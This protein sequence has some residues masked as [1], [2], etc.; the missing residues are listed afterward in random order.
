[1]GDHYQTIADLDVDLADSLNLGNEILAW[2]V[3][4]YIVSSA[5]SDCIL[6]DKRGYAPGPKFYDVVNIDPV[7]DITLRLRTNGL[8]IVVGRT[9][10]YNTAG[11][12]PFCP[13]CNA[14]FNDHSAWS[15]AANE[16]YGDNGPG[17][18]TCDQCGNI[19]SVTRWRYDPAW[20]FGNLGFKFWN[21]PQ[22][23]QSFIEEVT[24]RLAHQTVLVCG[25]I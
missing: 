1:M 9:V 6:S 5:P 19:Q 22:F 25:K 3:D 21:W 18:L 17:L 13:K 10:F 24:N 23:K 8:E 16:W 15:D 14:S 2:L 12:N 7:T 20:G 11:P 4:R